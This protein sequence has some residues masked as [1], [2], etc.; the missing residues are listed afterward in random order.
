[1][2]GLFNAK[3]SRNVL[4]S[5]CSGNF[6]TAINVSYSININIENSYFI[7]NTV[8][9]GRNVHNVSAK[10]VR[11]IE[12]SGYFYVGPLGYAGLRLK[13]ISVAVSQLIRGE[14]GDV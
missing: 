1:M 10:N 5:G 9:R 8:M 7:A 3:Y 13:P 6:D 2:I 12:P 4:I 14:Y 11:H